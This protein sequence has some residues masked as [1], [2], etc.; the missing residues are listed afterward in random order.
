L[1][2]NQLP[3][4]F[5]S[6][7]AI[8]QTQNRNLHPKVRVEMDWHGQRGQETRALKAT[9]RKHQSQQKRETQPG[10]N[11]TVIQM[12]SMKVIYTIENRMAQEFR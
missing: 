4:R 11:A 1:I 7:V 2:G 9:E 3:H 10:P 12:K 5:P 6:R 8:D